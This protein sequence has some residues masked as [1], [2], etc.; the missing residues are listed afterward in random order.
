M[1][2]TPLHDLLQ[3]IHTLLAA[4]PITMEKYSPI[5]AL[6]LDAKKMARNHIE[7]EGK[8]EDWIEEVEF[9]SE[10]YPQKCAGKMEII[11]KVRT[12]LTQ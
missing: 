12:I 9:D 6:L 11:N 3:D 7:L 8:I 4:L 10:F 5:S 1:T 2:E